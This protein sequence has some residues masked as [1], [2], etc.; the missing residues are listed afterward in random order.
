MSDCIQVLISFT[1][2]VAL[3]NEEL[4]SRR[5]YRGGMEFI[6]VGSGYD[7]VAP[8][9]DITANHALDKSVFDKVSTTYTIAR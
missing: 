8:M 7:F 5:D 1:R 6:N 9:L 3:L 2:F 4:R